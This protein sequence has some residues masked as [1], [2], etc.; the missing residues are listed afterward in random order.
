MGITLEGTEDFK[1]KLTSVGPR[2]AL[3]ALSKESRS[4]SLY[5]VV[6]CYEVTFEDGTEERVYLENLQRMLGLDGDPDC[7][8]YESDDYDTDPT[9]ILAALW[10]VEKEHA[11]GLSEHFEERNPVSVEVYANALVRFNEDDLKT[12]LAYLNKH[13]PKEAPLTMAEVASFDLGAIQ[14][15]TPGEGEPQRADGTGVAMHFHK[16]FPDQGLPLLGLCI[17]VHAVAHEL[18]SMDVEEEP[19]YRK[20]LWHH[21]EEEEAAS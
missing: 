5:F 15:F 16:E 21:E 2:I 11:D 1:F 13:M 6:D 20:V 17:L 19:L 12:M 18:D 14:R 7:G 10:A 8:F 4:G 3:S 9:D